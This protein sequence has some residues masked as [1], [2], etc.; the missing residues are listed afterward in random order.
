MKNKDLTLPLIVMTVF[1]YML[2]TVL[3]NYHGMHDIPFLY[4]LFGCIVTFISILIKNKVLPYFISGGY[5]AGFILGYILQ[6][7]SYDPGGGL[8]NNLW[9]LW[10]VVYLGFIM[11]GLVYPFIK[12]R[13]R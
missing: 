6:S 5:I 12:K 1:Y 7:N 11:V 8:L 13:M 3:F 4:F 10:L 9:I 2:R